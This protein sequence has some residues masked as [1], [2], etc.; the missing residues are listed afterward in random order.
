[1]GRGNTVV[2]LAPPSQMLRVGA[3]ASSL[4]VLLTALFSTSVG[5]E[6]WGFQ[7]RLTLSGVYTDNVDLTPAGQEDSD[8][9]LV[10]TPGF[11]LQRETSR[12]KL[13]ADYRLQT[14][15]F[16]ESSSSNRVNHELKGSMN[17]ELQQDFLFLDAS[18]LMTQVVVDARAP[19]S[20]DNITGNLNRAD[21]Q[22]Y[23]ISPYIHRDL[24]G[25]AT[26][27]L[28]Y[29]FERVDTD[30]AVGTSESN[31][32]DA[33]L[34]SG[35]RFTFLDWNLNYFKRQDDRSSTY[36]ID[37]ERISAA[38]SYRVHPTLS[39]LVEGGREDND[40]ESTEVAQNGSYWGAGA[41]WAPNRYLSISA[42]EGDRY[43]RGS[44]S[45]TP[46]QR[47]SL[48][49]GYQERDVGFNPGS[50]WNGSLQHRTRRS[51]WQLNYLED[52][53]TSQ[54]LLVTGPTFIV[55]NPDG[56]VA[57]V[58]IPDDSLSLTDELF[59]RKRAQASVSYQ[60][61]KST[62][63]FAAF[64]E[65]REMLRLGAPD[66]QNV[67]GGLAEWQW[68]FTG[69]TRANIRGSWERIDFIDDEREDD[70]WYVDTMLTRN[71]SRQATAS[72]GYRHV[73]NDSSQANAEYTENRILATLNIEF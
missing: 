33:S 56:T 24:S 35:R 73:R 5:A 21:A 2:P 64:R 51:V 50:T 36:D 68:Q 23:R 61:G 45:L 20:V 30:G 12:L 18:A 43:K 27:L 67:R 63:A 19:R 40:F 31:Y 60:T 16:A 66:D 22:A 46:S 15:T 11:S 58:V 8:F 10:A 25:L 59:E 28:R 26:V 53:Q 3:S 55:L 41:T 39:L 32:V 62:L 48:V 69:H 14:L 57:G 1:M 47:S 37:Q 71:L 4:F 17:A 34:T 42:L 72:L 9:I 38:L 29:G 6:G 13:D 7:P 65:Q 49:V 52:T 44:V 70:Y 54:R